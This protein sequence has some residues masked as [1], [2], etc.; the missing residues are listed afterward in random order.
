MP[1]F[2]VPSGARGKQSPSSESD[3]PSGLSV[4]GTPALQGGQIREKLYSLDT[5]RSS[6]TLSVEPSTAVATAYRTTVSSPPG[7]GKTVATLTYQIRELRYQIRWLS[8]KDVFLA[9]FGFQ[10]L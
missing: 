1:A 4:E 10:D 8:S 9:A 5:L 2:S 6:R 7:S 3:E